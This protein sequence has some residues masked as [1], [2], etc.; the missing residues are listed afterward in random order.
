ML[1][2]LNNL[3]NIITEQKQ[4]GNKVVF[5]NGCFD[6]LHAGHIQ[7]LQ[8]AKQLGEILV[9]GLNTDSSVSRL[10]G[11]H[12]PINNQD[13]RAI[14]LA[15]LKSVDFVIFFDEDTPYN[16]ISEIKPD[17]LVKGADY[18]EENV[19]GADIVKQNGGKVVLI[20]FVEGK[21]TTS[22]INKMNQ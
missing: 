1:I 9:I 6:I 2:S 15:E 12:R 5:T 10:K 8:K 22:I 11:P 13:D 14:V 18:E 21:S 4:L 3:K 20:P 7:Y 17:F 19:V 16:L